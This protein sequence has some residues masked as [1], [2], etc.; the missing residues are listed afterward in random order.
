MAEGIEREFGLRLVSCV[1]VRDTYGLEKLHVFHQGGREVPLEAVNTYLRSAFGS[2]TAAACR[3][4][5]A[6]PITDSGKVDDE[7][8]RAMAAS[9]A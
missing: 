4:L 9:G 2:V 1:S 8:L 7:K 5:A 6:L 3:R